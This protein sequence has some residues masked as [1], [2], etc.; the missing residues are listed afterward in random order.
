MYGKAGIGVFFPKME[1]KAVLLVIA[2][3]LLG[4]VIAVGAAL[5]RAVE[6]AIRAGNSAL[7]EGVVPCS[8]TVATQATLVE[9]RREREGIIA[10]AV[11]G[12]SVQVLG[13]NGL[14]A[15]QFPV[16]PDDEVM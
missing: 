16:Y 4:L 5:P 13:R 9:W 7:V 11:H 6:Q 1:R 12:I 14:R 10:D 15:I 2:F 3:E 8:L